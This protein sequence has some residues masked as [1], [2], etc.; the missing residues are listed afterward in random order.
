M[1]MTSI[2]RGLIGVVTLLL[3]IAMVLLVGRDQRRFRSLSLLAVVLAFALIVLGA[4][5][6]LNDAGLGCPDWPGCYGDLSPAHAAERIAAEEQLDPGGPVSMAKAWK[7]MAHRYLASILLATD[8]ALAIIAWRNRRQ[9]RRSPWLAFLIVGVVLLQAA[10]G[11]W[12]VTMRL[13]PIIVTGHLIGGLL[14]VSLLM[15]LWLGSRPP[16]SIFGADGARPAAAGIRG[17][18]A[19][20]LVAVIMQI[21]LGGWTST[22]YAALACPDFPTCQGQ[23]LPPL[24]FHDG[25]ELVRPLGMTAAGEPMPASA[26]MTIHWTHR[27][28]ALVVTVLVLLLAW[29]LRASLETRRLALALGAV[30]VLQVVLGISNVHFGLPL[31]V[32]TAH[33]GGAALLLLCLIIVNHRL[34]PGG[35]A[36]TV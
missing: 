7:E 24:D 30:L 31:A 18:A 17:L 14:S 16:E 2:E 26:L 23:W 25:Y 9:W 21:M 33:N 4:F 22:N 20:A 34:A 35:R 28:F 19:L 1:G 13:M 10:F 6:R 11:A 12:T 5:V 32:A 36:R 15:L 3:V 8:A 27:A 29:R